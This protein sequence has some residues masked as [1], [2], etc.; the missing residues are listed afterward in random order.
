MN[1]VADR[2]LIRSSTVM[3]LGTIASRATGFAR[4]AVLTFALGTVALGDAYHTGNNIPNVVYELLLGGILTSVVV[5]LLVRAQKRDTD[6]G[7]A[8]EQRLFTLVTVALLVFTAMAVAAAGPIIS[9]YARGFTDAQQELTVT[10]ARFFLPQIFFY[11]VSAMARATLNTRGH[12][13]A[14]MWTPVLN[15][16]V[17]IGVATT[18]LVITSDGVSPET[19]TTAE[20]QL[21]GLGT[22]LGIVVQTLALLPPM[23]R[24]GFRWRPRFDLR[25]LDYRHIGSMAG[26]VVAYVLVNQLGF[27]IAIRLATTAGVQARAAD[28][29]Y[30]AGYAPYFNAFQLFQLPYAVVAVSVITAL[31]PR[32][33][34]HAE[35]GQLNLVRDDFSSGLRL[36]S[37]LIVPG[38][39]A[40]LALGPQVAVL[41]FAHFRAT[42][43][44]A[45]YIGYVLSAF[46]V[47]LV[48]F[49]VY[50]L[51]LRVFYALQDTRTP[52]LIAVVRVGVMGALDV[53]FFLLLPPAWI[54]VG[55]AIGYAASYYAGAAVSGLVLRGR[56]DGIDGRRVTRTLTRLTVAAI[57]GGVFAY[58]MALGFTQTLGMGSVTSLFSIIVGVAVGGLLYVLVALRLGIREV[59]TAIDL[60]R[61][62]ARLG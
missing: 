46:A 23:H 7:E 61:R 36:T 21:L 40:L 41:L 15:N 9:L 59:H 27:L 13:A 18:F 20:T 19:L 50:Q 35:E 33:S 39:V 8:Y 10:L 28:V 44:D 42:V 56:L 1:T 38:A 31:L 17:V 12:F 53:A 37:V 16:L 51:M 26:W 3:A 55:L 57:P 34:R 60:L 6:G 2:S 49:S 22:T 5:P 32:M 24:V 11:G 54:V 48:G 30:G 58:A 25:R 29:E 45:V 47:G 14:P 43:P 4:T 62:R 52:A